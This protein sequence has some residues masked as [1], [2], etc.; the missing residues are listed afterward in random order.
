M[1]AHLRT[2]YIRV[3]DKE[4][5]VKFTMAAAALDPAEAKPLKGAPAVD[6]NGAPLPPEFP[7]APKSLSSQS[8]SGQTATTTEGA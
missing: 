8:N 7:E 4:S 3:Q 6:E 1:T 2:D 5:G